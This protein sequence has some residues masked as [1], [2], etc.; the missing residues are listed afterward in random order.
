[1]S[2]TQQ[3]LRAS[4]ALAKASLI[5][6]L[7]SPTSVVFSLLFPVIFI[8]VFGSMVDNRVVQLKIAL[9]PGCD[10]GNE[11]YKAITTIKNITIDKGLSPS[12]AADALQKRRLTAIIDI[13]KDT[14][15]SPLPHFNILITSS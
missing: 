6:T 8:V 9:A 15:N 1:M 3:Q 10:T 2:G 7:R 12:D 4:F 5:A 13:K 11:I 14:A